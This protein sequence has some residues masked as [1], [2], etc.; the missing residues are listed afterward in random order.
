MQ[1]GLQ[2]QGNPAFTGSIVGIVNGDNISAAYNCS[3]TTGSMAGIYPIIPSLVDPNNRETNYTV[4]L[5]NGTLTVQP[6]SL[7]VTWTNPVAIIYGT[8][9]STN[10]LNATANV[11]G[12]FVYFPTNGAVLDTGT[13]A[14]S[15]V[16][17]PSDTV[18]Y[19]TSTNTVELVISPAQLTVTADSLG[20]AYG[21]SNP[22]FTGVHHR[23]NKWRRH[24]DQLQFYR[25]DEQSGRRVFDYPN[26]GRS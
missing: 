19:S 23:S 22:T 11:P 2:G 14:L 3:A 15:V 1:A 18:D 25:N 7:T 16:F 20:K 5:V 10:E 21:Q 13:N 12:S 9:L 24:H 4:N 6:Q 17:I 26:L 8:P